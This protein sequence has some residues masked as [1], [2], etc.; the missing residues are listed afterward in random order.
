MEGYACIKGPQALE[1][2]AGGHGEGAQPTAPPSL[3]AVSCRMLQAQHKA[4]ELVPALPHMSIE[5]FKP[6]MS[7]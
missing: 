2:H 4:G 1:A 6:C 5:N 3:A 7:P